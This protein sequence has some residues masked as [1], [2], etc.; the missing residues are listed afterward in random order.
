MGEKQKKR[1][2]YDG[3]KMTGLEYKKLKGLI[4]RN[5]KGRK[6][7]Y[8]PRILAVGQRKKELV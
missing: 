3:K 2:A 5:G 7:W 6:S 4:G 8:D 1:G